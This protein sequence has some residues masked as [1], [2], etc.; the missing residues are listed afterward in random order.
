MRANARRAMEH[1]PKAGRGAEVGTNAGHWTAG[2]ARIAAPRTLILIDPWAEDAARDARPHAFT[3]PE[4]ER[5][6]A[7]A[8][9]RAAHPEARILRTTSDR[10][11]PRLPDGSLD[12]IWLDGGKHPDTIRADLAEAVRVVRPGGTIAGGGWHWGKELGRPV[13]HHVRALAT[14]LPGARLDQNGQFWALILPEQVALVPPPAGPRFLIVTTMKNEIPYILEWIAHHRA[15]GFTDFL[16]FTNDCEDGTDLLLD[17][18]Q[19][20]GLLTHQP[21]T[22]LKRGPHKSALYWAR[23]HVLFHEADWI[24][25]S[26]VDEFVNVR[27]GDRM[28][29]SLLRDLGPD[30]D[31]VSFP[32]KVFGNDGVTEIE[33]MPVTRRFTICEPV[34]KRG[35]RRMR[36]VKTLF[37]KREAM[38]HFGLHR[39]RLKDEWQDR[40]VWRSPS[41]ADIS[42]EMNG[43]TRWTMPWDGCADT[44]YMHHYPLRSREAYLIKKHRGRANHTDDELGLDYWRKWNLSGGRDESLVAGVPGFAEALA[45]LRED[46][47][48]RTLHRQGLAWHRAQAKQLLRDPRYA[49]LWEALG[50]EHGGPPEG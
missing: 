14:R 29:Q 37:R 39:P 7:L 35:G 41:G 44:A 50:A 1:L 10:V 8:Q 11:L 16:V 3:A 17:R 42:G 24:L 19:A 5:D 15:I 43:T 28:I 27:S 36:D 22:V 31:V 21:N 6:A 9:V 33:D 40:I 26:D 20:R 30:T 23:E 25:I 12:W 2:L 38:R 45:A 47:Q 32:W 4:A 48:T 13:R 46:R 49:A 18:L 34:P